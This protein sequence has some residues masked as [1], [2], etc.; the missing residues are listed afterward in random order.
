MC[1]A[2]TPFSPANATSAQCIA[3][4]PGNGSAL[5]TGGTVG[6]SRCPSGWSFYNDT[7]GAWLGMLGVLWALIQ[8]SFAFNTLLPCTATWLICLPIRW[9][10]HASCTTLPACFRAG[11]EDGHSC[12][13]YVSTTVNWTVA[14]ASCV[15]SHLLTV[16]QVVVLIRHSPDA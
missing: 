8:P 9:M 16:K 10:F 3:C 11:T 13:A 7:L 14:N 2:S 12:V 1:P 4:A 15:S 6:R 5:C